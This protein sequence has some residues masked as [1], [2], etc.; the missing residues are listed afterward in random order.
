MK[1]SD[2]Q[3]GQQYTY[4]PPPQHSTDLRHFPAIVE[5]IG[6]RVKVKV[7]MEGAEQGVMKHVS[8]KRLVTQA[9]LQI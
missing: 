6:K 8:A 1:L 4:Y 3:L 2:I 7:F 9:E 5:A